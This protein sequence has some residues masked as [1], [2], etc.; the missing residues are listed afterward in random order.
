MA[1]SD[2]WG[3]TETGFYRPTLEDI[4]NEKNKK[5]KQIFGEDFDV[6]EKTPQ[7]KFF[8]V[9]AAA[10]S[11]LCEIA[12]G[13]Y[14]SIF[15]STARGISL[16]RVCD[17]ANLT[18]ENA[19]YAVLEL[20]VIGTEGHTI[21][22][23]T[24][25]K[26]DAG[27]EFY[28]TSDAV[29][30]NNE[31]NDSSGDSEICY[32]VVNVQCTESGE[33]GNV[34]NVNSLKVVD[35]NVEK[36]EYVQNIS[37]GTEIESDPELR[38]KFT[39]VIQGMGTNTREA[40]KANVLRVSGVK[41][42]ILIDNTKNDD[43]GISQ[44]LTVAQGTY[45]IV[46]HSDDLTNSVEVAKAIFEKQPLGIPQS[47]NTFVTIK[48]EAGINQDIRFT[49]VDVVDIDVHIECVFDSSFTADGEKLIA[50]NIT[51]YVNS[52]DIGEEVV[53]SRLYDHIYNVTG[54]RKVTELTLNGEKSDIEIE[55]TSIAKIGTI[56]IS[57][58]EG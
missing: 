40:I 58:K 2:I 49:Y 12:E 3:V 24:I 5:A 44:A 7:G 46:V 8:R 27:L 14:Y 51:S 33:I 20:K 41:N 48:D 36:V 28:S 54:V 18:R 45:A 53:F 13:I 55:R 47:G 17:F 11:K 38:E 15:P 19:G 6:D 9:N 29:I 35:T 43:M 1:T 31:F 10:E 25:F 22:A 32:A 26:N 42:V 23:G 37:R 57:E 21:P 30:N 50:N 34:T 16:D 39:K 52:L 4:I 56:T